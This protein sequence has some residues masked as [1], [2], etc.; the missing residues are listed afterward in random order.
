MIQLGNRG[1]RRSHWAEGFPGKEDCAKLT[2]GPNIPVWQTTLCNVSL[3]TICV[4]HKDF[5]EGINHVICTNSYQKL[6]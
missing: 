6:N 1:I 3:S 5:I 2:T 4:S